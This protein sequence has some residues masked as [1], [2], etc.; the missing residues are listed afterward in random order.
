MKSVTISEKW[1]GAGCDMSPIARG[2]ANEGPHR[3]CGHGSTLCG[4]RQRALCT[5]GVDMMNCAQLVR[6]SGRLHAILRGP[7]TL[8][9]LHTADLHL[10]SPLRSLALKDPDLAARVR[11]ASRAALE[12]I[13]AI[14]LEQEVAALLIA[15]DLYD[16]QERSAKTAAY[17]AS[18]MDRLAEAGIEVFYIKG[19]HDAINPI[20]GEIALPGNVHVFG[21]KGGCVQLGKEQ[22][23]IHGVSFSGKHAPES[24]LP[25]FGAPVDGAVN[26][27]MLHTSLAGAAGHDPYAPC[28][29]AELG[30]MGFDYWAL[31]HVH[32]RQ[33]HSEAP[34]IVMPGMPQGRDIGEAGPKSASLI[35]IEG[36]AVTAR[37][38]ATSIAQFSDVT[39]D[40]SACETEDAL[41]RDLRR[42][43]EAEAE[44]AE[45]TASADVAQ[46]LRLRMTGASALAWQIRRDLDI[47]EETAR[48]FARDL[49][50]VW[51]EKLRCDVT[52]VQAAVPA[53]QSALQE[54]QALM[55]DI[56][57]EP[58][59]QAE[60]R[61][62]LEALPA[63]S[64]RMMM[65][66]E[67]AQ[68]A[69]LKELTRDAALWMTAQLR[70]GRS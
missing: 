42:V 63:D 51:I 5:S 2:E 64:R 4:D 22:V 46:I 70:G 21:P 39:W 43:L 28:S 59:F 33:V 65:P 31:G 38:V 30:A 36:G 9:I 47:W 67:A 58:D 23:F 16:G 45:E 69:L 19:N 55:G 62:V 57:T 11:V 8:R 14:C 68:E 27:A 37:P 13:V 44:A 6:R 12:R 53:G 32:K 48:E 15:G 54:V 40:V 52:E 20:S 60:A 1:R 3:V 18:A 56:L 25:Q 50:D 35:E 34:W 24:L 49:G 7:M 41:R 17:F 26:I 10:D 29:V 61:R 66:D